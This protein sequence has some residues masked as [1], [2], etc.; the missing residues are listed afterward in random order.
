MYVNSPS[1]P[2]LAI[3]ASLIMLCT[4]AKN[5][6]SKPV[7]MY[8]SIMGNFQGRCLVDSAIAGFKG[9]YGELASRM[10]LVVAWD[11]PKCKELDMLKQQKT[12]EHV[13]VLTRT[14]P[15]ETILSE[16]ANLD[17]ANADQLRQHVERV[18]QDGSSTRPA[19]QRPRAGTSAVAASTVAWTNFMHFDVLP[20]HITEISPEYLWYCWKHGVGLQMAHSQHGIDGILPVFMGNLDRPFVTPTG[21]Q[22][23]AATSI[24]MH[25]TH[26]MTYVAWEAKN[27]DELQPGAGSGKPDVMLKLAGP[28]IM[29]ALHAPPGEKP[30]T[31]RALLCVLLDLGTSTSFASKP[32]G[33][34][35]RV[36]MINGTECPRLCI[37]GVT[38]K[39]TYP[40][41]DVLKIRAIFEQILTTLA[42]IPT[43]EKFNV[44]S[45]PIWNDRVQPA[46]PSI[47]ATGASNPPP[48]AAAAA[49]AA[50][51]D[52]DNGTAQCKK[53][54][55][56]LD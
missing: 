50:A 2:V 27:R 44:V 36:Q 47:S 1:E 51:T 23:D 16:L 28:S 45:N 17:K 26:Y 53:Q 20:E 35:P 55:M 31:E 54:R 52:D 56:D 40:C 21:T 24:E 13:K 18:Q 32:K 30:L 38:N 42:M 22:D 19:L 8:G 3:A 7:D 29:C 15:L 25:A 10:A 49:A 46:L 6:G 43:F 34:R 41:L 48:S 14:V 4:G 5:V 12:S 9:M 11:A 39:H 33:S 37:R